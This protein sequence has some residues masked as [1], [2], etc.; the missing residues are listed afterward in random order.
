MKQ[1]IMH[2]FFPGENVSPFDVNM[3]ADSG[4][5]VIVP[6]TRLAA[7]D[8]TALTQDCIYSR[9]PGSANDTGIFIGGFDVNLAEDMYKNVTGSM[10]TPFEVSVMVDPNGAYTTSAALVA[11]ISSTLTANNQ[12]LKGSR[13]T[14]YGGGPVGNCA[15]VLA[16]RSGASV[17]LARLTKGSKE[18]H[19]YV[20][21]F[22]AR[23]ETHAE[24]IDASTDKGKLDA[25]KDA[26][27]LISSAKAGIEILSEQL[28]KDGCEATVAADVNAVPPAGIYGVGLQDA[29]KPLDY[30]S[31]CNGIGALAIGNIKYQTQQGLLK[32]M[33][34]TTGGAKRIGVSE[35]FEV[36]SSLA[37]QDGK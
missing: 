7:E 10:Q 26:Q 3:I 35:A 34:D 4:Y 32:Q 33:L 27:V 1:K 14:I 29:G 18:K 31:S 5:S 9:P 25:M 36:A 11:L 30:L 15:A 2:M 20:D 37:G 16:A 13:V 21:E 6:Y 12:S 19:A 17:R 22:L 24:Q 8:A 23:Y 28:I